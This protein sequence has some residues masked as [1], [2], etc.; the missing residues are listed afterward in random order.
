MEWA[1][2]SGSAIKNP[3]AMQQMQVQSLD[4]EDPL[5]KEMATHSGIG[6]IIQGHK[7]LD[8]TEQLSGV[9]ELWN[10]GCFQL[11]NGLMGIYYTILSTFMYT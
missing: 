9:V 11:K 10:N 6:Y 4:H 8:T 7:E 2:L 1:S 5:E 3:P